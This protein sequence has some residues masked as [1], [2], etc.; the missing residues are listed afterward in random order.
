MWPSSKPGFQ[1]PVG[2]PWWA[3]KSVEAALQPEQTLCCLPLG[4]GD[5]ALWVALAQF[6]GVGV[7][8]KMMPPL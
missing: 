4:P 5:V 3:G 2:K 8:R 7:C 6:F 1:C